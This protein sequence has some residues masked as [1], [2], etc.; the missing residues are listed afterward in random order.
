MLYVISIL[1]GVLGALGSWAAAA[2]IAASLGS[3]SDNLAA[4]IVIGPLAGVAGFITA[5]ALTLTLKG[6]DRTF[7]GV[8]VRSLGVV[9]M[10]GALAAGGYGLRTAALKHLGL[11]AKAPAVEFEIRLPRTAT[12]ADLK[13][14]AQV[15]LL[16]DQNQ[17]LAR[18]DDS[19]RA[20]E[21]GRAVLR[22]S[23]PLKFRTSDRMV[24]LSLPGQAQRAF[25]LRL[26]PNPSPS[27]E[28]GPW[29][30]VDRIASTDTARSVPDDS[31]AIRYRV[32]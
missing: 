14:E 28:F 31:F 32:L 5:V 9:L 22:G 11:M 15:E 30:L 1:A 21:D 7:R 20:T 29:H 24:V 4:F 19:L 8:A 18:I 23:V 25:K 2:M 27:D 10:V 3:G 12:S 6:D 26:P 13:R 17:T 16:T